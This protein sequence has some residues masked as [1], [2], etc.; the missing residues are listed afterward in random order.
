[1]EEGLQLQGHRR[2]EMVSRLVPL[3]PVRRLVLRHD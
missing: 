2:A 3:E 1:M